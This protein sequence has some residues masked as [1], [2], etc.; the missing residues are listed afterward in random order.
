MSPSLSF[1]FYT[2]YA[3][4]DLLSERPNAGACSEEDRGS[5]ARENTTKEMKKMIS[6][7]DKR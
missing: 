6:E 2:S 4:E 7:E 3:N 1:S 5:D